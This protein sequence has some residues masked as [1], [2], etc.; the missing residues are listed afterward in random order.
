MKQVK[1]GSTVDI[2]FSLCLIDGTVVD[3]TEADET[4]QFTLGDGTLFEGLE[5]WLIG[6]EEGEHK[7]FTLFPEDAFGNP[8]PDNVQELSRDLF[9]ADMDLERGLVIG[10]SGPAGDDIPGTI[11]AVEGD[12]VTV[13]FN[14]PLAGQVLVFDVTVE[15]IYD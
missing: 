13:D 14:H 2:R 3:Q 10:F 8:D 6:L 1:A 7:Q 11:V 12:R 5:R 4:L 15:R 9:P